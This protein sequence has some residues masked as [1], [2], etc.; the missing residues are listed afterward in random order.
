MSRLFGTDGVRGVANDTLSVSLAMKIGV[1]GAYVLT[2]KVHNPVILVAADTRKSGDMLSFALAAGIC[3]IGGDV[4]LLGVLP[5]PS[6]PYLTRLY[7][8][9][10]AVM[11]SA[12]HNSMEYNGI[13]WFDKNGFKL[14]D[15][16]EDKIEEKIADFDNISFPIGEHVGNIINVKRARD[17]YM[18][19]LMSCSE[20]EL[21]GIKIALDCANGAAS[22]IAPLIFSNLGATVFSSANEPDGCN[23]NR[24]C[25]STHLSHISEFVVESGADVG[26]AYDGDADRVLAVDERGNIV[27]GDKLMGICAKKLNENGKLKDSTLVATV[28]SN[29]GLTHS[30]KEAGI[31]IVATKVGDRYVLERMRENGYALGGEQSGHIIFYDKNTSGDG[32]LTSIMIMNILR[33]TNLPLSVLA[34]EIRIFPQILVNVELTNENLNVA[35]EDVKLCEYIGKIQSELGDDG[36][37]LVRS[38]GTEPLIRIMIEGIDTDDIREKALSI[39]DILIDNYDGVLRK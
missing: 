8:A 17:D 35:M 26:F 27:D 31:N 18:A 19:F 21:K 11:I 14:S 7:G 5:T 39:A 13:K 32:I 22:G 25:G 36:R 24:N 3:A 20:Y 6:L 34:D 37:V 1:A 9:D 33:K 29:I 2:S 30:M 23:I 28:M 12:S 15:D 16:I 10:A 4:K 38:S